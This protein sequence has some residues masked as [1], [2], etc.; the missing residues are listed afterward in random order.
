MKMVVS[1]W[2]D[3]LHG[4][5]VCITGGAGFIG[6]NLATVLAE[7]SEV[8]VIDDLATGKAENL[9][10]LDIEFC[11]GSILDFPLLSK[12]FA[13]I[14]YVFHQAALSSVVRSVHN[15]ARSNEANITG[16][17]NVLMAAREAKVKK[18]VFASSSS[19]YGDTPTLPK[20]E[21][22][23]CFPLSPYAVSKFA[24]E[25]Y[26]RVFWHNYGFPTVSL[27]YFNVFGP[28]QDPKAEY[29]A[30]IPIFVSSIDAGKDL[31]IY[32]DGEQTRDFTF[33]EDVV[34]ANI[35]AA[36]SDE[37][38]GKAIN[39]A[40]GKRAS[41]N[42]LAK[43]AMDVIG[44]KVKVKHV[45]ARTGDVKHTLADL[46]LAKEVLGYKPAYNLERGLPSTIDYLLHLK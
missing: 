2:R 13:G 46:R 40:T 14:D 10:G 19:V 8:M 28:R 18:V 38:N 36:V 25:S 34:Q 22:M 32:G 1:D 33:V 16:T 15:P 9:K 26:C 12:K 29:A 17:L 45:E 11:G 23:A 21:D 5:K 37:A 42:E 3:A 20:R 24:A 31:V 7:E 39:V 35:L 27:R 4:A 43:M 41:V 30:V 6:S 44:K